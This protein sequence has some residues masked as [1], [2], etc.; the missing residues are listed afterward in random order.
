M[1]GELILYTAIFDNPFVK[2]P[3][4]FQKNR[5]I[6]CICKKVAFIFGLHKKK[7]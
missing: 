5:V 4:T 7:T 6:V 3:L 1:G 2:I